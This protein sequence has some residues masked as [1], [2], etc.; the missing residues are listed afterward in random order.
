MCITIEGSIGVGGTGCLDPP[1]RS[2][3][4][5]H[6]FDDFSIFSM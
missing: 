4:S 2:E 5:E 6:I 1:P 3:Y